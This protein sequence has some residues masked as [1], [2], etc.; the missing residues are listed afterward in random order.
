MGDFFRIVL[1][2]L[3]AAALSGC[4][5][6]TQTVGAASSAV[7]APVANVVAGA[8]FGLQTIDHTATTIATTSKATSTSIAQ[9]ARTVR[10]VQATAAQ[11]RYVT[12]K[13]KPLSKKAK[14]AIEKDKKAPQPDIQVLP[15]ETIAKLSDDQRGLQSAAQKAALTAPV[16]ETIFWDFEG[17]K[18][19]VVA[20]DEHKYGQTLCRTFEHTVTL[21]GT[22][23]DAHADACLDANNGKW[24]KA[25]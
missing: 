8:N 5:I 22:D 15:D 24:Q 3:T 23:Y 1:V 14:D 6:A 20:K 12:P 11:P 16:G 4:G 2:G 18:G 9:S 21:E 25:F 19:S 13:I 17:G 10:N 7:L